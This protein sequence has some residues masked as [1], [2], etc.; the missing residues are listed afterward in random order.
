M[1]ERHFPIMPPTIYNAQTWNI[2]RDS[3][4]TR[5]ILAVPWGMMERHADQARRNHGQ[6]LDRLAERGGLAASEACAI[7]GDRPWHA[8]NDFTAQGHLAR[9]LAEWRHEQRLRKGP[10]APTTWDDWA[11]ESEDWNTDTGAP[12]FYKFQGLVQAWSLFQ[13]G[14]TSVAEAALALNV[15]AS[16][17]VEAASD[18]PYMYLTGP[19]DDYTR[20]IIEHDGE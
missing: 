17:I 1:T 10:V 16:R 2:L 11:P 14:E 6:T 18:H 3:G 7:L 4:V 8:M 5:I 19:H 20:L 9:K 15:P 13:V 12:N